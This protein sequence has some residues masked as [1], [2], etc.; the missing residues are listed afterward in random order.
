MKFLSEQLLSPPVYVKLSWRFRQIKISRPF[1]LFLIICWLSCDFQ[2]SLATI[3]CHY[4]QTTQVEDKSKSI[5]VAFPF[6]SLNFKVEPLM[7]VRVSSKR[8]D[9][10]LDG[11]SFKSRGK[12]NDFM[13]EDSSMEWDGFRVLQE[14]SLILLTEPYC[15]AL[16]EAFRIHAQDAFTPPPLFPFSCLSVQK[17]IRAF[18]YFIG[19]SPRM[20]E[21]IRQFIELFNV[22]K[23]LNLRMKRDMLWILWIYNLLRPMVFPSTRSWMF[24]VLMAISRSRNLPNFWLLCCPSTVVVQHRTYWSFH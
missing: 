17:Q 5:W 7:V 14:F 8:S 18:E 3:F 10:K 21:I 23:R 9:G 11:N 2:R 4:Q 13:G 16:L 15:W 12:F 22:Q 6:F 19:F 1:F 20:L 24:S